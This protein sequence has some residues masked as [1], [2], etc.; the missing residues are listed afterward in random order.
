MEYMIGRVECLLIGL[1]YNINDVIMGR[2]MNL[3]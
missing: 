3:L 1:L 2:E